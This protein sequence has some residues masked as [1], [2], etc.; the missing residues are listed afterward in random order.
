MGRPRSLR[1]VGYGRDEPGTDSYRLAA[2]KNQ[3]S[4]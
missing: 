4:K 2:T 1:R 3:R